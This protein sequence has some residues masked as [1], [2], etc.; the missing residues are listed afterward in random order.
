MIN[1]DD[2]AARCRLIDSIG[3]DAYNKAFAEHL[4]K[5]TVAT[6]NGHD[7]RPVQTRFGR[8]FA[9]GKTGKAYRT[10]AE[11]EQFAVAT[12]A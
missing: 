5:S 12:P 7:I 1:W 10:M 4:K 6:I 2:P 3:P 8:L 11:A 9:V